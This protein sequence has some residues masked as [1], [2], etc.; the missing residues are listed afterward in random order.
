MKNLY[1]TILFFTVFLLGGWSAHAQYEV[2]YYDK[3]AAIDAE[4]ADV[5][6]TKPLK[7]PTNLDPVGVGED[8][9][10]TFTLTFNNFSVLQ[11]LQSQIAY[12]QLA[13]KQID[14]W[15]KKQENTTLLKEMN[16]QM[17]K[18][19]TSFATAQ[20]EYFKFYEGGKYGNGGP[21]LRARDN[22]VKN[23][24][25]SKNWN[26][27][28]KGYQKDHLILDKW[29]ECGYCDEFRY[30]AME[31]N[32][33]G[34]YDNDSGPGP[35]F[36]ASS[37]RDKAFESFGDAFYKSGL[38]KSRSIGLIEMADDG[39]KLLTKISD[40]RVAHYRSLAW[41]EKILQMSAYLVSY[42][43]NCP[44]PV[45][46]C[47]PSQLAKYKP[48]MIWNDDILNAW[49]KEYSPKIPKVQYIFSDEYLQGQINLLTTGS[50][51][52]WSKQAVI[53]K[54]ERER[55]EVFEIVR[56]PQ[57]AIC[58]GIKWSTIAS[59]HYTTLTGLRLY[60][61]QSLMGVD[62]PWTG[63]YLPLRDIC[64]EIP[65]FRMVNGRKVTISKTQATT[66]LKIGWAAAVEALRFEIN[67]LEIAPTEETV[68]TL[69]LENLQLMLT[70]QRPGSKVRFGYCSGSV[71][72]NV[73][74]CKN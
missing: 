52:V 1:I 12:S 48:P 65:N 50:Y 16:R 43:V 19:Y 47:L 57:N 73:K 11:S 29:I 42:N 61:N 41:Q 20:R 74:F 44:S 35:K 3:Q 26:A 32:S 71:V 70:S 31:V 51:G 7:I 4:K 49:A 21:V 34:N 14:D 53:D 24:N 33:L 64:V 28:V 10:F 67:L 22:S 23:G 27:K 58:G 30:L 37:F 17:G 18:N 15:L 40:K 6:G 68:K 60:A 69:F 66:N 55:E 2:H 72:S 54:V 13:R 56:L 38:N 5:S 63:R 59:A 25:W 9:P 46:S 39:N 8:N 36:Y 45:L 62:I